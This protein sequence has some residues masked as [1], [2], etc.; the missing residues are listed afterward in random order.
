M[1]TFRLLMVSPDESPVTD[2]KEAMLH[3]QTSCKNAGNYKQAGQATTRVS[4]FKEC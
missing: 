1:N 2:S 3:K 4:A